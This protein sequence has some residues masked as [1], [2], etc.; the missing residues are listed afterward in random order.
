MKVGGRKCFVS[1]VMR[2]ECFSRVWAPPAGRRPGER[3][4]GVNGGRRA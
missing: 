4:S 3:G 2:E 1:E